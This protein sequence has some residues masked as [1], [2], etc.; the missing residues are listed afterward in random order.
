MDKIKESNN[1]NDKNLLNQQN[2]S[3]NKEDI[4]QTINMREIYSMMN[5]LN[6]QILMASAIFC[7]FLIIFLIKL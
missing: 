6:Y 1:L 2:N 3:N 7:H 4:L 5:K